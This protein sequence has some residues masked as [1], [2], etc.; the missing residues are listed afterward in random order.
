MD[1]GAF[2]DLSAEVVRFNTALMKAASWSPAGGKSFAPG[3]VVILRNGV[4]INL[5]V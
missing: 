3:R 1:I 2:Y 5:K 4:S